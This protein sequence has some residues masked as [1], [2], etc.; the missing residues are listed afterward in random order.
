MTTGGAYRVQRDM[1]VHARVSPR[2]FSAAEHPRKGVDRTMVR[3]PERNRL[4]K[5]EL[6]MGRYRWFFAIRVEM[7]IQYLRFL[8]DLRTPLG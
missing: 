4:W 3:K 6:G 2:V 7:L 5:F 8:G 1:K